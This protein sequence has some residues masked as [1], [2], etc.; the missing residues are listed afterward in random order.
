MST[1][2]L[3]KFY[4]T[5]ENRTQEMS[6]N[7]GSSKITLLKWKGPKY[8]LLPM[9][10]HV[11]K[12]VFRLSYTCLS[13]VI[14]FDRLH[15]LTRFKE[16]FISLLYS[17]HSR[18]S[19]R[20]LEGPLMHIDGKRSPFW[21]FRLIGKHLSDR[22]SHLQASFTSY[23][24][25]LFHWMDSSSPTRNSACI[26]SPVWWHINLTLS[27][28]SQYSHQSPCMTQGSIILYG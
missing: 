20:S 12:A 17:Y 14:A 13:V 22:D 4:F 16:I 27:S 15:R 26:L 8:V 1:K 24:C 28:L 11:M 23:F 21:K 3:W 7:H 6:S 9:A 25:C 2:I 10:A 18:L 5:G 19:S